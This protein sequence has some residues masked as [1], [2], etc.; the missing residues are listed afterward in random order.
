MLVLTRKSNEKIVLQLREHTVSIEVVEISRG[1]VRLGIT[2]PK[3]V[4]VHRSEVAERILQ[5]EHQYQGSAL[6]H[7]EEWSSYQTV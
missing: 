5:S 6:G 3:E 7:L 1:K 2:A 4:A